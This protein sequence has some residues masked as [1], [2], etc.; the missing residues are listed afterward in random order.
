MK[1][2]YIVVIML[3][4]LML[5]LVVDNSYA[6]NEENEE[7]DVNSGNLDIILEYNENS[8]IFNNDVYN[9]IDLVDDSLIPTSS[10]SI[11]STLNENYDFLT[12]FAIDFILKN[13]KYFEEDIVIMDDYIYND[14]VNSY[15]TNKYVDKSVIYNITNNIFGKSNYYI[16]NDYLNKSDNY[17]P[18]LLIK[19]YSFYM[20]IDEVIEY[21]YDYII[22]KYKNID[23]MYKYIFEIKDDYYFIKNLIVY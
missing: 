10:F 5:I 3:L 17:I 14:G 2:K 8:T 9:F 6:I 21:G 16:V 23:F 11:S 18:L 4:E 1:L 22:L 13:E 19:D 12:V 20:E 7:V 15:I